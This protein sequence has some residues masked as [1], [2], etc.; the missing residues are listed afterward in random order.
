MFFFLCMDDKHCVKVGKPGAPVAA[1]EE[2]EASTLV[3]CDTKYL[4]IAYLNYCTLSLSQYD[5]L[6]R[7]VNQYETLDR[8]SIYT[9]SIQ[10]VQHNVAPPNQ[11]EVSIKEN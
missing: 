10:K 2:R 4:Y 3:L 1:A 8:C 9:Y 11:L 7:Y 6:S 5:K